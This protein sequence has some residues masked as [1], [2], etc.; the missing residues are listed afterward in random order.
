MARRKRIYEGKAK[1][2]Y[3]GPEPA[4]LVLYFMD[5]ASEPAATLWITT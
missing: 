5:V 1:V 3:E 2:V 4:T